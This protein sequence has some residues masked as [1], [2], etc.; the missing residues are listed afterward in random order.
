MGCL[1]GAGSP[2]PSSTLVARVSQVWWIQAFRFKHTN[3]LLQGKE[4]LG[5][6]LGEFMLQKDY[7]VSLHVL[8]MLIS[9]RDSHHQCVVTCPSPWDKNPGVHKNSSKKEPNTRD[10]SVLAQTLSWSRQRRGN[11]GKKSFFQCLAKPLS[12][13]SVCWLPFTCYFT[14]HAHEVDNR[15]AGR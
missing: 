1:L 4:G 2:T 6:Y 7:Q 11:L 9:P 8:L 10:L 15:F 5:K 14:L 12:A 3:K 13:A